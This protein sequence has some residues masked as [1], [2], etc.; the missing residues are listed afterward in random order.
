MSGASV[1]VL[2]RMAKVREGS[3]SPGTGAM[4]SYGPLDA[5]AAHGTWR[6]DGR[7]VSIDVPRIGQP[8]GQIHPSESTRSVGTCQD[9]VLSGHIEIRP[10][11]WA[12]SGNAY[13]KDVTALRAAVFPYM[14][15]T[16][17]KFD[18]PVFV[19]T[20]T[21]DHDVDPRTAQYPLVKAACEAGSTIE[22]Q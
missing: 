20:G 6:P 17:V 11:E 1:A 5:V 16:T 14:M 2:K 22:Q 15:Y 8:S 4:L 18:H 3:V 7:R 12:Y 21:D 19:G 13:R 9:R 10:G